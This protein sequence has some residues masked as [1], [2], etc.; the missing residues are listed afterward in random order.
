MAGPT[1]S[2]TYT[3]PG[4]YRVRLTVTDN[5]MATGDTTVDI[6]VAAANIPPV[7]RFLASPVSGRVPLSVSFDASESNDPDGVIDNYHWDFGDGSVEE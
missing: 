6:V 7:A 4:T 3:E 5:E 2:H 1:T